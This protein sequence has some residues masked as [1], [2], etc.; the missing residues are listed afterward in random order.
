MRS[1]FRASLPEPRPRGSESI[2]CPT[3]KNGALAF[4]WH[5]VQPQPTGY[6]DYRVEQHDSRLLGY[7]LFAGE[8]MLDELWN[9]GEARSFETVLIL[10]GKVGIKSVISWNPELV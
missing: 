5:H 4:S 2:S 1:P 3:E 7:D 10:S 9:G 8:V 6:L